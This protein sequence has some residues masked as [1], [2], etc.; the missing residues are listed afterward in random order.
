MKVIGEVSRQHYGLTQSA[1]ASRGY[2]TPLGADE[3]IEVNRLLD[4]FLREGLSMGSEGLDKKR[5]ES[6]K[7]SNKLLGWFVSYQNNNHGTYYEIRE[8]RAFF[9]GGTIQGERLISLNSK[10]FQTVHA[11]LQAS[12][13]A[14]V[15]IQD[16]F[17][18][19]G[20]FVSRGGSSDEQPVTSPTELGHGDWVQL[21]ILFAYSCVSL[22]V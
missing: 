8:G 13:A 16:V 3:L 19:S 5:Q 9:G 20:T 14:G 6:E 10:Q 15:M 17:S 1:L 4:H 11:V 22:M 18:T 12:P 2:I 21:A 7:K